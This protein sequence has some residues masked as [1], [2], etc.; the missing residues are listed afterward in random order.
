MSD[1]IFLA[2]I[3]FQILAVAAFVGI[4]GWSRRD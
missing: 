2:L 3:V 4:Y 1:P